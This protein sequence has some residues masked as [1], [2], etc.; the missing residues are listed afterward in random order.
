MQAT[1]LGRY[2]LFGPGGDFLAA[3]GDATAADAEPSDDADWTVDE[4]GDVFTFTN[5][6]RAA[7]SR[8]TATAR[9]S[10]SPPAAP[11]RAVFDFQAATGLRRATPRSRS[12]PPAGPRRA[13]PRYGEVQG[14]DRGPH[15][16]DGVR[17]PRRPTRTA[18]GRGTAS[19]PPTRSRTAPTTRPPTAAAR[20]SRTSSTATPP[21]AT[22]PGGWPDVQRLARPEVADPRADL[23]QVARARL[24]RRPAP[25]R[26]PDGREPGAVRASIRS[27]RTPATRWTASCCRSSG[28]TSSQDYIDAQ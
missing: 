9:W 12:T 19:A 26:E 14:T 11:A 2:L 1:D 15:A 4:C 18:A 20:C 6:V 5:H 27:S 21:A 8:S 22:T 7:S 24:A 25:L 13:T 3:S 17:V 23:L 16:R 10:R 28:S